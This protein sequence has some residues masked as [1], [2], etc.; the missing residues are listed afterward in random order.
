MLLGSSGSDE[1]DGGTGDDSLHDGSKNDKLIGRSGDDY[2]DGGNGSDNL[3]GGV[4]NDT[5][6]GGSGNDNLKGGS[7]DDLIYSGGN[8]DVVNGGS[9]IDTV[10]YSYAASAVNIDIHRKKTTG[11][12]SDTLKSI[13]NAVG[14]DHNDSMRGNRLNNRLEG[15]DGDDTIRGMKGDDQLL[16]GSGADTFAWRQSDIDGSLDQ[17]L[18][19]AL[20]EDSLSLNVSASLA[21]RD[22]N[23]WL[24]L[25]AGD[26]SV[27][28]Y[29]DLE[30]AATHLNKLKQLKFSE[31][32]L[33]LAKRLQQPELLSLR[34]QNFSDIVK[35]KNQQLALLDNR[36]HQLQLTIQAQQIENKAR[37]G[38]LTLL[39]KQYNSIESLM[40]KNYVSEIQFDE[41][42]QQLADARSKIESTRQTI[43]ASE[44]ELQQ[45]PV[46]KDLLISEHHQQANLEHNRAMQRIIGIEDN[47]NQLKNRI[48]NATVQASHDGVI[49]HL[50]RK[51]P[52]ET[53]IPGEA[54]MRLLPDKEELLIEARV[55]PTD[56]DLVWPGQTARI[57]L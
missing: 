39:Q 43:A 2:L 46:Q 17:I 19:F 35:S 28:L 50:K 41:I 4:G 34:Q 47:I 40:E 3:N 56:I 7:G 48:A 12:D 27:E 14:S 26:N 38:R 51:N 36:Q 37:L 5:L 18:D 22:I 8:K 53:V 21:D 45:I 42:S 16:G 9:G 30:V 10:S 57:R 44:S 11:G 52:G 33:L 49:T 20:G 25:E 6:I 13:E 23:E 29:A 15:G 1:L 24:Q 54:I 31:K 55:R 32:V